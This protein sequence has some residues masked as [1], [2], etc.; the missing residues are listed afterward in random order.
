MLKADRYLRDLCF[1][2]DG[3]AMWPY[4]SYLPMEKTKYRF[5]R[6]QPSLSAR[7]LRGPSMSYETCTFCQEVMTKNGLF[8]R[9]AWW[10]LYFTYIKEQIQR[11]E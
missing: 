7:G 10:E 4:Q 1:D 8:P 2:D 9:D 11:I 3:E 6:S 5:N